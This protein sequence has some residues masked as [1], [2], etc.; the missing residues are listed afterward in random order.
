MCASILNDYYY[1]CGMN[2]SS[3]C[4]LFIIGGDDVIP[5]PTI[6]KPL[7]GVGDSLLYSDMLY[8]FETID[9]VHVD[10]LFKEQPR[11]AVGRLPL[12]SK[13]D[14]DNCAHQDLATYLDNCSRYANSG[15]PIDSI[16]METAEF[17]QGA[18]EKMMQDLQE[19]LEDI[20]VSPPIDIK[21]QS[22]KMQCINALRKNPFFIFNLHGSDEKAYP[23]FFG[24]S[25]NRDRMVEALSPD[26][27]EYRSPMIFNTIACHGARYMGYELNESMLLTALTNG[28]ML[29]CG[30]CDIAYQRLISLALAPAMMS[31]YNIYLCQG[32]PAGMAL[33]KAKQDYYISCHN[34][35]GDTFAMYTILEFNLFGCPILS[36]NPWMDIDYKSSLYEIPNKKS[37]ATYK[38]EKAKALFQPHL[39]SEDIRAQVKEN[40]QLA[41]MCWTVENEL[42][43][44]GLKNT[45]Q[46][47]QVYALY[48]ESTHIGYRFVYTYTL[49]ADN[50]RHNL[51]YLV[52]VNMDGSIKSVINTI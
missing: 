34:N 3:N 31:F 45:I 14:A 25:S 50:L 44:Q 38:P 52:E 27:L 43:Q 1:G 49:Y 33:L 10:Y 47:Q 9:E 30:A 26:L 32:Y 46:L 42:Y 41:S 36:M 40:Q 18:A 6:E 19:P 2:H 13:Q 24:E 51:F 7:M 5:M 4:P 22:G 35:D 16:A 15:I 12:V 48:K 39:K 17:F 28:T 11:F 8:C 37:M 23:Q 29:Y 20:L 21:T